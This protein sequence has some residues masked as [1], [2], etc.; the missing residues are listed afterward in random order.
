ML[1]NKVEMKVA[2]F[3]RE[4]R[5]RSGL[6]QHEV[7]SRSDLFGT[8]KPILSQAAISRL[9]KRPFSVDTLKTAAYLNAIGV[10]QQ[11][12]HSIIDSFSIS[13]IK[14]NTM[15]NVITEKKQ[16]AISMALE[17]LEQVKS[18]IVVSSYPYLK[19]FDLESVFSSVAASIKG[20]DRKPVIGC[21]G[22]F[23]SGK[24]TLINTILGTDTLPTRFQP[25]TSVINLLVH[26]EDRPKGINSDVMIMKKGFMP[27][28]LHLPDAVEN[29]LVDQGGKDL[30]T[31]L[32]THNYQDEHTE[33]YIAIVFHDAEILR[34]ICLL[35]TP[36]DTEGALGNDDELAVAGTE[37]AEGLVFLSQANGFFGQGQLALAFEAFKNS[38]PLREH[39][40]KGMGILDHFLIVQSHCHSEM[41]PEQI[42]VIADVATTRTFKQF[43][44]QSFGQWEKKGFTSR[45]PESDEFRSRIRPFWRENDVY[46]SAVI[47]AIKKMAEQL[48]TNQLSLLEQEIEKRLE[49]LME[50]LNSVI[51]Q[52]EYNK[53]ATQ[54]RIQEVEEKDA[55]FRDQA[56]SLEKEF[57]KLIASCAQRLKSDVEHMRM[58]F[59]H[60]KS[61]DCLT[62]KIKSLYENKKDAQEDIG[63]YV[64]QWISSE[65]Q[66]RLTESGESIS[67]KLE[68]LIEQWQKIVPGH[69][70]SKQEGSSEKV[71]GVDVDASFNAH[72]AFIG[73]LSGLGSL[74]AM[75]LYVSTISSNLGAYILVGKAAGV[76]T[77]L[78]I[79]GSVTTLTSFVA[80]IGGPIT[81]GLALAAGIGYI[82]YRLVG[83][84]WEESLAKKVSKAIEKQDIWPEIE[85]V[86]NKYWNSTEKSMNK[87][88]KALLKQTDEH[89]EKM[90]A[91]ARFDFDPVEL[92]ECIQALEKGSQTL[93]NKLHAA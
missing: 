84:S 24:S 7:V 33:A 71:G 12:Y 23:D 27:N 5:D 63:D 4:S 83:G 28:M 40:K 9:E 80:A 17:A 74:G 92:S 53:K 77:S 88:F 48:E 32:G 93:A 68:L 2:A 59:D 34:H 64:G 66:A 58:R 31:Q 54:E 8:N 15:D 73:G 20:L 14:G 13:E 1:E 67:S 90:K 41:L 75:A 35:D 69:D 87:G 11:E 26:I 44:E 47:G 65:L 85:A 10:S 86:V 82:V 16:A 30:L 6:S 45:L 46:R 52:L 3:L 18:L 43:S 50:R 39:D 72:A 36:G 29:F 49:G 78:G 91:E 81:I 70:F 56:D 55:R 22:K 19:A 76:L 37:I 57:K 60:I 42:S 38:P 62:S 21:F 89:R 79:T 51:G 25:A 61:T